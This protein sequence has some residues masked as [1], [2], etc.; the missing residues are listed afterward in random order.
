MGYNEK[1]LW[2]A[3]MVGEDACEKV[4]EWNT[5]RAKQVTSKDGELGTT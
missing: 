2:F 4:V 1:I 5:E 3:I